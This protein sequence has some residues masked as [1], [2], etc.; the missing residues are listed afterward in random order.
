VIVVGT[1][2]VIVMGIL[3]VTVV[4]V[5]DVQLSTGNSPSNSG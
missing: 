3:V 1:T 5:V 2:V 4:V